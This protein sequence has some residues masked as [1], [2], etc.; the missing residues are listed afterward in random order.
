MHEFEVPDQTARARLLF[1]VNLLYSPGHCHQEWKFF[2]KPPM[3]V[4][5]DVGDEFGQW[6]GFPARTF[7]ALAPFVFYL[8]EHRLR[9]QSRFVT[10]LLKRSIPMTT[11][12]EAISLKDLG[13]GWLL[14]DKFG[15]SRLGA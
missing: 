10:G 9:D 8:R 4:I 11:E 14:H 5:H 7:D 1:C 6:S 2:T 13:S 12:I 3:V 15:E